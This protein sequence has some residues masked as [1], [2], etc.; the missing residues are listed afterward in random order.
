[1]D[2]LNH[3]LPDD[4]R[5]DDIENITTQKADP[6]AGWNEDSFPTEEKSNARLFREPTAHDDP[7]NTERTT[8]A[9]TGPARLA[10]ENDPIYGGMSDA[11]PTIPDERYYGNQAAAQNGRPGY[12]PAADPTAGQQGVPAGGIPAPTPKK[13]ASRVVIALVI[14]VLAVA[15][16]V[17]AALYFSGKNGGKPDPSQP[18]AKQTGTDVTVATTA[19]EI[20][21][22]EPEA[23]AAPTTTSAPA[24]TAVPTTAPAP[25]TTPAPATAATS[26]SPTAAPKPTTPQTA[27]TSNAPTAAPK[28]TVPPTAAPTNA[29][30]AAPP[31]NGLPTQY[32]TALEQ[33]LDERNADREAMGYPTLSS[34]EIY[35]CQKDING[36][37]VKE[38]IISED[39]QQEVALYT[40]YNNAAVTVFFP[41]R[42][43]SD[44]I[45]SNGMI[46]YSY[47]GLRIYRLV[48]S[49]LVTV[50]NISDYFSV[51][52]DEWEEHCD[53]IMAENGIPTDGMR[54]NFVKWQ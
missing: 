18:A 11:V 29:P 53:A 37:G 54:F 2:D 38:L 23:T 34:I 24:T 21:T 3:G 27:A 31:A 6:A 10:G 13:N 42:H 28:T 51:E 14:A 41:Q 20:T 25:A 46:T 5:E 12:P 43:G 32:L 17:F 48:G 47:K 19:P 9:Y 33:Y 1:M 49:E 16:V 52:S 35:Y 36:D 40:I 7:W 45:L 26:S 4:G 15:V 22:A 50:L 39:G 44:R 8:E 30:T